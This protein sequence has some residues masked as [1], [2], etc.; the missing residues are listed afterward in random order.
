M[1]GFAAETN[2]VL[3]NA[4]KK[5]KAKRLHAIVVNDISQPGIGFDSE[6]NAVTILTEHEVIEVPES[7]KWEVAQRVLDAVVA[8][9]QGRSTQTKSTPSPSPTEA[10]G[11]R[12]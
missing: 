6:R 5:M 7:S 8:I 3:E 1:V 4:R 11:N 2:N 9:R 12:R 10:Q